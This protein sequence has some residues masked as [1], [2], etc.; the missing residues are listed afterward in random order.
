LTRSWYRRYSTDYVDAEDEARRAKC[1]MWPVPS[2]P[3]FVAIP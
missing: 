1:G 3:V 2:S